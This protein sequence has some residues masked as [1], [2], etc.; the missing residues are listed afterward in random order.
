[1]TNVGKSQLN[2]ITTNLGFNP[3]SRD[4][5][6][7]LSKI[8]PLTAKKQLATAI[9]SRLVADFST[10][11]QNEIFGQTELILQTIDDNIL[12]EIEYN[13]KHNYEYM[14]LKL[15]EELDL[16]ASEHYLRSLL[17][18]H[19]FEKNIIDFIAKKFKAGKLTENKFD[20]IIN[21]LSYNY[22]STKQK[23]KINQLCSQL[24]E[25][26]NLIELERYHPNEVEHIFV[27]GPAGS[28]KSAVLKCKME[29]GTLEMSQ[30]L[31]FTPDDL[32]QKVIHLGGA[33]H[34]NSDEKHDFLQSSIF[35]AIEEEVF[36]EENHKKS[37]PR[38]VREFIVPTSARVEKFGGEKVEF[39]L[40]LHLNINNVIKGAQERARD[41]GR[42]VDVKYI[43]TGQIAIA[44]NLPSTLDTML[45]KPQLGSFIMNSTTHIHD[46]NIPE[47]KAPV[48]ICSNGSLLM[49]SLEDFIRFNAEKNIVLDLS[50][51]QCTNDLDTD[52]AILDLFMGDYKNKLSNFV[53]INPEV[54]ISSTQ[55]LND[56]I[57]AYVKD[58]E[59][60]VTNNLIYNRVIE[61]SPLI[62]KFFEQLQLELQYESEL[63]SIS[64]D[65][66]DN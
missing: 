19:A 15:R 22:M 27:F 52:E 56:E 13:A 35:D 42:R 37:S 23:E 39:N 34:A 7:L 16:E 40:A 50:K 3:N 24:I 47:P 9:V 60:I 63:Y 6:S 43:V 59:L 65:K 64:G 1:L 10:T 25:Q 31:R 33:V 5:I 28:G 48:A 32:H 4:H 2:S 62:S 18:E 46:R 53:F 41:T 66:Y 36:G 61:N 20:A 29:Q 55:D 30:V 17:T 21:I 49:I 51:N 58:N 45:I 11:S 14:N 12:Y 54:N 44:E 38:I 8:V 26:H 57:Y